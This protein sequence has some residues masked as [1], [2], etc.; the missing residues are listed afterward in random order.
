MEEQNKRLKV[1]VNI[2]QRDLAV[3]FAI[4]TVLHQSFGQV[5]KQNG[6][7]INLCLVLDNSV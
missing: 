5:E 2:K 1:I 6:C 4:V 7:I 3:F